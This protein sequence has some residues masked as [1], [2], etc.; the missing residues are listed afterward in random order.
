MK[1]EEIRNRAQWALTFGSNIPVLRKASELQRDAMLHAMALG[2]RIYDPA[3]ATRAP[4]ETDLSLYGIDSGRY[5]RIED[6]LARPFGD[7]LRPILVENERIVR[8]SYG[9]GYQPS[10][11]PKLATLRERFKLGEVVA[12]GETELEQMILLRSWGRSQWKRSDWQPRL[13]NFDLLAIFDRN[14]RNTDGR[15]NDQSVNYT[16]C[17]FFPPQ[18]V[19]LLVSLGHTARYVSISHECVGFHGMTEVWSNQH[20]KWIAMD[21]DLNLYYERD[22]VPL[23]LF[24]VHSMRYADDPLDFEMV[25]APQGSGDDEW[26]KPLAG[27]DFFVSYHSYFRT[28]LRNDWFTN[29]YFRGHPKRSEQITLYFNDLRMPP[30]RP[31]SSVSPVTSRLDDFYWTL[32]QAEIHVERGRPSSSPE[33]LPLLFRTV[34]P[35]FDA[36]EVT[37]DDEPPKVSGSPL[38]DW[39]LHPGENSLTVRPLNTFGVAGIASR[40]VLGKN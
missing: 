8:S 13:P 25:R 40:V 36:F 22:G 19:Q 26:K 38:F 14:V 23:S 2:T 5:Q 7:R 3:P 12:P 32:N 35:N 37:I 6:F 9:F 1:L 24:E 39:R 10:D 31:W 15:E 4:L 18:Y 20:R 27:K 30:P 33:R 11:E 17:S 21:A 34:T 29:H 16:P 28:E